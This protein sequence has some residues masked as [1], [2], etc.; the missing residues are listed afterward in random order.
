MTLAV[1]KE[2]ALTKFY[3]ETRSELKKVVWPT[4]KEWFNLTVI[5]IATAV[6]VGAILGLVDYIFEKLILL[7]VAK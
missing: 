2:N 1:K 6:G 5:V 4:Q 7:F 3:K